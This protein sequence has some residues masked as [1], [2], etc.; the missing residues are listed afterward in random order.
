[1]SKPS[2]FINMSK[3]VLWAAQRRALRRQI[4]IV[5]RTWA[6]N[7]ILK[8]GG[9][10]FKYKRWLQA[11]HVSENV[12]SIMETIQKNL[13]LLVTVEAKTGPSKSLAQMLLMYSSVLQFHF[14][15]HDPSMVLNPLLQVNYLVP[16]VELHG[17][18]KE[19]TCSCKIASLKNFIYPNLVSIAYWLFCK[20]D[21]LNRS[22]APLFLLI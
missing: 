2:E 17:W 13:V 8:I 1:M 15:K 4:L 7:L 16:V 19:S 22:N 6:N 5:I 9:A 10:Q 11:S 14:S 21:Y 3:P 20:N 18:C 12:N